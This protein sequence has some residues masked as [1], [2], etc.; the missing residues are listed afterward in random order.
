MENVINDLH[1]FRININSDIIDVIN[2]I[3]RAIGY[4]RL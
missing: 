1:S 2:R 4:K 3:A